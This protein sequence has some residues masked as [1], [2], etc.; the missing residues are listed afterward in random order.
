LQLSVGC[1]VRCHYIFVEN[2]AA[3]RKMENNKRLGE[4]VANDSPHEDHYGAEDPAGAPIDIAALLF[5]KKALD[6]RLLRSHLAG[7]FLRIY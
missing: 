5:K 1:H 7:R 3:H 2:A 4:I 6:R